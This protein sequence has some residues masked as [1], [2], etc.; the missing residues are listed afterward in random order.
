MTLCRSFGMGGFFNV[1]FVVDEC[2]GV[3]YLLEINRRIVT[4]MHLGERVGRD[5]PSR[6]D[7]A[8]EG[9]PGDADAAG[10]SRM[11]VA[12]WLSS[13]ASGCAIRAVAI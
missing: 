3:P 2:S 7:G 5:L 13:R 9:G 10:R 11:K 1:Q 6:I 4:H 8:L 12:R